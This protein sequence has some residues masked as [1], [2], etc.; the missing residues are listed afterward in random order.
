MNVLGHMVK[1]KN[2]KSKYAEDLLEVAKTRKE[3]FD[4]YEKVKEIPWDDQF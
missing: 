3:I 4:K 2:S 1:S